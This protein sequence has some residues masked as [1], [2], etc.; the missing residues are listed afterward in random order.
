[1]AN[2]RSPLPLGSNSNSQGG[3][4]KAA[5]TPTNAGT[6]KGL[7]ADKDNEEIRFIGSIDDI[8][9]GDVRSYD[10]SDYAA[11]FITD[12]S[13]RRVPRPP[14]KG[15]YPVIFVNGMQGSPIK[16]R[17]QACSVAALSG[18]PVWGVYNGSGDS[19]LLGDNRGK[20]KV[21]GNEPGNILVDLVECLTDKLQSTDWDQFTTWFKKKRGVSQQ[22]IEFDMIANLS[23]FNRA[24]G[25]L[26]EL[27]LKPG[28]ENAHIVAHSQG[29]IITCNAVNALAAT[30]GNKAI[31]KMKIHAVASPV[32][33]WSEAGMF[34]EDI[35]TTHAL[36]NDLVAWLGANVS[37]LPFLILRS[38]VDREGEN[39]A[40]TE[41]SERYKWT[42]NPFQVLTHNFY[43]YLEKM[44][45]ELRPQ[46]E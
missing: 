6:N 12:K 38:P 17:A 29:N 2:F 41:I 45:N 46:F 5:L 32:M 35:V 3:Q 18:G 4:P 40:G 8:R 26:Y 10:V 23:R 7:R 44:W 28:F 24:A 14:R 31:A 43:A 39:M 37:D 25:S 19:F 9:D 11:F 33:F 13:V 30:R 1:M 15:S 42:I 20:A 16:F 21:A 34:G 22:Q 36:A 27:L